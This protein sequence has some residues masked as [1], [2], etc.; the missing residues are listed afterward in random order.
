MP[1]AA[2]LAAWFAEA[3]RD[4]PWRRTRDPWAILVAE[5]M[6]QQTQVSRVAERWPAFLAQFPDPAA[7]AAAP[8]ADVI[9]A[10]SGLGYNRRAV[11]LHR[12]AAAIVSNHEGEVPRGRAQLLALPGIGPYTARAVRVFAFEEH[13][14]VVDTNVARILARVANRTLT[15]AE[16]QRQADEWAI[17]ASPWTHNQALLDV[18]AGH[19]RAGEPICA[20]CPLAPYCDWSLSGRSGADPAVGSASVSGRQSRFD[21]SDRQGRGRLLR[22][23]QSGPRRTEDAAGIMGWPDEPDRGAAV[24]A[25]LV[26]DGLIEVADGWFRLPGSAPPSVERGSS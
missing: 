20:G 7:M 16:A 4:L 8:L 12:A 19:C 2:V 25:T 15:A 9:A 11:Y 13:D 17:S 5:M 18:G 23:L 10:W 14:A 21:G 1:I 24:A 26:A 22:T 3:G 6:L